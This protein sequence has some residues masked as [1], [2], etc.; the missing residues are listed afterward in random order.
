MKNL[1]FVIFVFMT[2]WAYW[3]SL[4]HAPKHDQI[5]YLAEMSRKTSSWDQTFGSYSLNRN[6]SFMGK[7]DDF[8]FR[9]LL[10]IFLGLQFVLFGYNFTLWQ[11]MALG[12]HLIAGLFMFRLLTEI[13]SG[14]PAA[15][16]AGFFLLL[17][18]NV[19]MVVWHHV[20][21]YII[22][23]VLM[24]EALVRLLRYLRC[25]Q[26]SH[27]LTA[28]LILL[29]VASFISEV[30]VLMLGSLALYFLVIERSPRN[31]G[32]FTLAMLLCLGVNAADYLM[33]NLVI[34]GETSRILDKVLSFN[35]LINAGTSF[36]WFFLSGIF[37]K[38]L[39]VFPLERVVLSPLTLG[40]FWPLTGLSPELVRGALALT[41]FGGSVITFG[42]YT[43]LDR[44]RLAGILLLLILSFLF[45]VSIGRVNTRGVVTGLFFN[46]YYI[47]IF[48]AMALPASYC[49]LSFDRI[50]AR[51]E[52][53]LIST[54]MYV[55][56]AALILSNTI[57]IFNANRLIAAIDKP[58]RDLLNTTALFVKAHQAEPSF[59]FYVPRDCPGNYPGKWL[60]KN[61]DPLWRR[62]TLIEALYPAYYFEADPEYVLGC[63]KNEAPRSGYVQVPVHH[64]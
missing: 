52:G 10:N 57:A 17:L 30:G 41:V 43:A 49:V 27:P 4:Q 55:L 24:L 33:R 31:A 1:L 22:F 54:A 59:S 38:P 18:A 48:W 5:A 29:T 40:S 53:R 62:Y 64:Q 6:R 20:S 7:A 45:F 47:Y 56:A 36:K 15:M 12:L 61:T 58:R 44:L 32:K 2:L 60:H 11:G 9:P 25:P 23:C 19:P 50:L 35:T 26:N 14:P 21:A 39:E 46:S 34:S 42:R 13:R 3:P 28:C 51:P 8:L 63:Q 16:G 37:L